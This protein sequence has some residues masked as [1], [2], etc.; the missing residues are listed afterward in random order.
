LRLAGHIFQTQPET[1]RIVF[2]YEGK[3]CRESLNLPHTKT[4]IAY[5]K[6]L[7]GEIINAI[8]RGTFKYEDYFPESRTV[9]LLRLGASA[10]ERRSA[11]V[12]KAEEDT[13]RAL[14]QA[15]LAEQA[16]QL[17]ITETRKV[18]QAARL[19]IEQSRRREDAAK[20]AP[21]SETKISDLLHDYLSIAGRNLERSSARCYQ[22]VTDDHL[23]PKW[24]QTSVEALTSKDLRLWIM[25]LTVKSKTIQL[26]LTPL[27]N[28][29]ELAVLDGVIE[30]NPFDNVKLAKLL[31]REQRASKF[32]ADPFDVD[33]ID[34]ILNACGREE[35]RNMFLFAFCTG[36]RPSEYVALQWAQI[37]EE[38]HQVAVEQV[39]VDGQTKD[40]A[41][42]EAGLRSIDLRLGARKALQAQKAL[43]Q[44]EEN[45]CSSIRRH[46][47]SGT[48]TSPS[49]NG[50]SRF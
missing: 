6:R 29:I 46:A 41:K 14:E 5:A 4:N 40:R 20:P 8:E 17:A 50:G 45:W 43:P 7:Q 44:R 9:K 27:R 18:E 38:R 26:I 35:D 22:Q 34:A 15:K 3:R 10:A 16:A 1:I 48:G 36:M 49:I 33:E 47:S 30:S 19:A 11:E 39:F 12:K 13:Q 28:A 31:P 23:L 32:K 24:G 2:L 42:T 25:S 21:Q 37:R